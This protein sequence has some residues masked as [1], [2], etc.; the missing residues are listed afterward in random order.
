MTIYHFIYKTTSKSGKYYIGRHSTKNINDKYF[1]SGKWVRSIKDKTELTREILE[2]CSEEELK[3]REQNYLNENVGK[4]NCMNFNLS[5]VGFSTGKLNPA[6]NPEEKERRSKSFKGD[7]NPA[8]RPEVRKKMSESQKGIERPK[9]KMSEEGKKNIS[10]SR[11]GIKYSEDGRKKLSESRKRDCESGKRDVP[12]FS[13]K[14]HTEESKKLLREHFE[15]RPLIECVHC[16][17][18]FHG[19]TYARWH[20]DNC[21]MQYEDSQV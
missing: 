14:T 9:W 4:L 1:G 3:D 19:T 7:N 15:K 21:K 6:H 20:G 5:P 2:F 13:G 18:L 10:E 16:G 12:S 8:K 11:K 17:K